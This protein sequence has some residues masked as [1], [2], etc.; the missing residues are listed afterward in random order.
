MKKILLDV[1][2]GNQP[3]KYQD[4][5]T[6]GLDRHDFSK[7][8]AGL[9]WAEFKQTDILKGIPLK[10]KSVDFIWCHHALEHLPHQLPDGRDALVFMMNE[11][12]RVIKPGCEVHLI[13]P[14]ID[15]PNAWRHPGHYRFF[16]LDLFPWFSHTNTTPD[17]EAY[18]YVNKMELV[19]VW[20]QDECHVY[21]IFKGL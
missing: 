16:H 19:K 1:G 21:A 8:Y 3:K 11:F 9:D 18:G 2:A 6:I 4:Y 15:H 20:I 14:W 5:Y 12:G 7:D 10:D 17:H 13:V